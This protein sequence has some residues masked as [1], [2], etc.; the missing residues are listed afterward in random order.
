MNRKR[1][2]EFVKKIELEDIRS[3]AKDGKS[4]ASVI[5]FIKA[6]NLDMRTGR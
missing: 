5:V 1:D 4:S 6:D 3:S 2:A